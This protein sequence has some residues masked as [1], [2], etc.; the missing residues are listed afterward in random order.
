LDIS[1]ASNAERGNRQTV[2]FGERR[3]QPESATEQLPVPAS[4]GPS[5]PFIAYHATK[6]AQYT[7]ALGAMTYTSV[8]GATPLEAW[9]RALVEL[10]M[11]EQGA[12]E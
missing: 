12:I 8:K 7:A 4:P 5:E 6:K 11:I 2:Y 1:M 3:K 9:G 10:K